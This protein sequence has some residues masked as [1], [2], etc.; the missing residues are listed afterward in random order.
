QSALVLVHVAG[1]A[2]ARHSQVS[3]VQ[4]FDG[5][6]R[7]LSGR[8]VRRSVAAR[9]RQSRVLAFQHVTRLAVVE[10]ARRWVPADE[11]EILPVVLGVAAGAL[12]L[13]GADAAERA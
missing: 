9:A 6:G 5:N 11:S 10:G 8:D 1:H 13:A 4:I 7:A 2:G 12:L 3:A